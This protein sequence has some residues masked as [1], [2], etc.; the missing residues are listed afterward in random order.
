MTRDELLCEQIQEALDHD[1]RIAAESLLVR[2]QSGIVTL[3]GSAPSNGSMLAAIEVVASFPKCRGVV[4]RQVLTAARPA[5]S[6]SLWGFTAA[7]GIVG[8]SGC[9][10]LPNDGQP[11]GIYY[12]RAALRESSERRRRRR[13]S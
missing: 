11:T 7:D 12:S 10:C 1:R 2:S 5:G 9:A 8:R 6:E 3:E 13:A 4:N